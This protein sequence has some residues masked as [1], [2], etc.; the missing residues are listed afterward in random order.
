MIRAEDIHYEYDTRG[1]MMY[2]KN[3]P[4]GGAGIDKYA[5]GCRSNLKLFRDCAEETKRKILAGY[6]DNY[7]RDRIREID[8]EMETE[9]NNE[10]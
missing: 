3:K 10:F 1:Y 4:I 5:K 7:M 9:S 6:I 2:Y 8:K